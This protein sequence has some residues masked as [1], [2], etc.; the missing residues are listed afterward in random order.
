MDK[1]KSDDPSIISPEDTQDVKTKAIAGVRALSFRTVLTLGLRLINQI[2]TGNRLVASDYGK[3]G[4]AS[5][6][7]GISQYFTDV[8]LAGALVRQESEIT[9]DESTTVF[10][11]QQG[12][13]AAI[14][15]I[16]FLAIP[17]FQRFLHPSS[18]S[19]LL[20][21]IMTLTLF[22]A[23]ARVIPVLMME[24]RLQF[25]ELARVE[26]I[27]GISQTIVTVLLVLAGA[28]VWSLLGGHLIQSVVGLALVWRYSPWRPKG[29]FDFS[30]AKRLAK[31]G[32]PF[33]LN[34]LLPSIGGAWATVVVQ[35]VLG[36]HALGLVIWAGNVA[37]MPIAFNMVFIRV[38]YPAYSRLLSDPSALG[39]TLRLS[40]RKLNSVVCLL[41]PLFIVACPALITVLFRHRWDPAIGLVQLF[42]FDACLFVLNGTVCAA[43]NAIGR[44]DERF[45]VTVLMLGLR[46]VFGWLIVRNFGLISVGIFG[47]TMMAIELF[48]SVHLVQLRHR[49]S[50]GLDYDVFYPIIVTAITTGLVIFAAWYFFPVNFL[51]QGIFGV[52]FLALLT[53]LREQ[54]TPWAI[55]REAVASLWSVLRKA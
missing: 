16:T 45:Y 47:I 51:M 55:L 8:G 28:G 41:F 23:S 49:E 43:Q 39:N 50:K 33:Q 12:L 32:L 14:C 25:E 42:C 37:A 17:L 3:F 35:R 15:L 13:T 21:V 9:E 24:R 22:L 11:C 4:L 1:S 44:A 34:A 53:L 19:I 2:F 7:A 31:F 40:M 30:I 26:M 10:W 52:V 36:D 46:W 5:N 48:L 29:R 20:L 27:G 38:A 6:V 54:F 18:E